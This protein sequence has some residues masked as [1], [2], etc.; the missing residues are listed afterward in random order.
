MGRIFVGFIA[1]VLILMEVLPLLGFNMIL[2]LG[3]FALEPFDPS[4]EPVYLFVS[5][6]SGLATAAFFAP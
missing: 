4:T 5:R 1:L 6:S 2:V 3:P